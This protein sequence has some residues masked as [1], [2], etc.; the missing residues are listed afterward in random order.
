MTAT[1]TTPLLVNANSLAIPVPTKSVHCIATSP[2]YWGLRDYGTAKWEGGDP[3]CDHAAAQIRTGMG[4]AAL[5]E[6]YRGGGHKQGKIQHI[7]FRGE[8][9]KCGAVRED[10]QIGLEP[11]HDCLAWASGYANVDALVAAALAIAEQD[12]TDAA[13]RL[14]N[15]VAILRE[16]PLAM[17]EPSEPCGRCYVCHMVQVFRELWRVLRD[18]GIVWLNLGDS[19]VGATSEYAS[20]DSAGKNSRVG[21]RGLS[22]MPNNGRGDRGRIGLPMKNIVGVPWRVAL[23]LQADGWVLRSDIIWNKPNGM[24]GSQNDR[25]TKVHE[26][27][28]LLMKRPHYYYDHEAVKEPAVVSSTGSS[29]SFK[30]NGSKREVAHVNQSMGTRQP[31]RDDIAYDAD[32]R[33]LRSVWAVAPAS[34]PGSHFATWPPDLV[35]PMIKAGTSEKGCCPECGTPWNRII[36][37]SDPRPRPDNPNPVLPYT[38][39]SNHRQGIDGSTLHMTRETTTIGWEPGCKC[40]NAAALPPIPCIVLD[41]FAGSGT[42][43]MV[44]RK[45]GRRSIGLDLSFAYLKDQAR[46]RLSLDDLDNFER[47]RVGKIEDTI[48][49]DLPL[50]QIA[51]NFA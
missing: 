2:P 42:T 40:P 47:G 30:R 16:I 5:G 46:P 51:T 11:L 14:D 36:S 27:I 44:A 4:L 33:T 12:G 49:D 39:D 37:K 31:T 18:D 34:Y 41:P 32:T 25:P 13:T 24:P 28:F 15:V 7:Q 48:T 8:C 19:Y 6:R 50:F 22:G 23:A 43:L 17:R 26:Y 3:E 10:Q 1:I 21:K 35:E 38:A 29:A 9:Q 45:L 20:G